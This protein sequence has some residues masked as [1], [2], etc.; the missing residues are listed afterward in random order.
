MAS[1]RTR[2]LVVDDSE[3]CRAAIRGALETDSDVEVVG[4]AADGLA[5]IRLVEELRPSLVTLDIQMPR[6]GGLE[7]IE[8]IMRLR[9][10]PILVIT[11]QPRFEGVDVTFESLSRGALELL[12]KSTWLQG[13][14][15]T[16]SLVER[17]KALAR[18]AL[19]ASGSAPTPERAPRAQAERWGQGWR[20]EVLAIAASTGGPAA[21]ATLLG[22]LPRDFAL[23]VLVVQHM[24]P[25][26]Q[27]SFALWL[28]KQT[29]L[30]VRLAEDGDR[31]SGGEVLLAP[32]GLE[33][34]VTPS[35]RVTLEPAWPGAFHVP[36]AD[37]LFRS[38][39]ETYGDRAIG[40]LL[41][42]MGNDGASGLKALHERGALTVAQDR[43]SSSIYG[44]P[45][46][47]VELGAADFVMPVAQMARF[48]RQRLDGSGP[49]ARVPEGSKVVLVDDSQVVL[50]TVGHALRQAGFTVVALDNPL[51]VPSVVR[52]ERP[53]LIVLDVN[54]PALRGD[55][56]AQIVRS[57]G[58]AE[59]IPLLLFSERPAAD[60]A[61][62]A[63]ECGASGFVEKGAGPDALVARVRQELAAQGKAS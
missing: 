29:L 60:L 54:M 21:L 28:R 15:E 22:G 34:V 6:M 44:M 31:L 38:V 26:F 17:V 52:R 1:E 27:D 57:H 5:A 39:A 23:P 7:T 10:T 14:A 56:V 11:E 20:P 63:R 4:E 25:S 43:D 48:L 45:G 50:E 62:R 53:Q 46:A 24:H 9:P 35:R 16:R 13:G 37:R 58:L 12:P 41:T 36:S 19:R 61:A 30:P 55:V 33:L 3:V 32:Q 42:G 2:V 8:R 18:A 47:A 51:S 49:T 40:V 59:R